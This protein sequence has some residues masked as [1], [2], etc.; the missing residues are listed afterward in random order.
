MC[1]RILYVLRIGE[2]WRPFSYFGEVSSHSGTGSDTMR[3]NRFRSRKEG[4]VF[5]DDLHCGLISFSVIRPQVLFSQRNPASWASIEPDMNKH[6]PKFQKL[7]RYLTHSDKRSDYSD[8]AL[9]KRIHSVVYFTWNTM[10]FFYWN[11]VRFFFVAKALK[12]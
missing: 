3:K 11:S 10:E 9:R 8:Y 5:L 7:N 12:F 4:N 6:V 2:N 1:G